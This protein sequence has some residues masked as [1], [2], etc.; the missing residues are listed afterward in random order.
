MMILSDYTVTHSALV[1]VFVVYM[2]YLGVTAPHVYK[3]CSLLCRGMHALS[4]V[5]C[6][7]G[8]FAACATL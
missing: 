7:F 2:F 6:A 5:L 3:D 4:V 8:T 1:T